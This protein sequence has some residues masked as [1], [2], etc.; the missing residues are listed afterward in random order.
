M[1]SLPVRW[2]RSD[3]KSDAPPANTRTLRPVRRL[4]AVSF[5]ALALP[6][7]GGAASNPVIAAVER[8]AMAKTVTMQLSA[9]TSVGGLRTTMSGAGV[10]K[11]MSARVSIRTQA[12]GAVVRV[13]AIVLREH[14]SYVVYMRSPVLTSKLPR[15]KS[16]VRIDLSKAA[17][18]GLAVDFSS[19]VSSSETFAP[20]EK[21]LVSTTREGRQVVVGLPTTHY[22]ALVD[23]QRAARAVPAYGAQV[24]ALERATGIHFG[25]QTYHVWIAGDGRLRRLRFSMPTAAA[26]LRGTTVQTMT[27]RAF[28]TP[29]TITA[30]PRSLVV[31]A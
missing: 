20:L 9:T 18:S 19:L 7:F 8:T 12:Q 11:G 17:S 15:G 21:G 3:R 25:R 16:W 4:L 13:D 27:F 28:D 30:P 10:Q 24:A 31:D 2:R 22:R 5:V 14:G 29:V 26:G 6:A 23:V 1:I